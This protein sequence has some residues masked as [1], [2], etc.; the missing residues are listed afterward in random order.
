[1]ANSQPP[2]SRP[3]VA[4]L[5]GAFVFGDATAKGSDVLQDFHQNDTSHKRN[6]RV[7]EQDAD[8]EQDSTQNE[9]RRRVAVKPRQDEARAQ[10]AARNTT[11]QSHSL[12]E[13]L[14][15]HVQRSGHQF[16]DQRSERRAE[17]QQPKR[18]PEQPAILLLER[19]T[20]RLQRL[21]AGRGICGYRSGSL[22]NGSAVPAHIAVGGIGITDRLTA[23][24]ATCAHASY[25]FPMQC[26]VLPVRMNSCPCEMAME[27]RSELSPSSPIGVEWS[28]LKPAVA[29]EAT[30]TLPR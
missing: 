7:E 10:R 30:K 24:W 16:V 6:G 23:T 1:M 17:E 11:D 12:I 9:L 19:R 21:T 26:N 18:Q 4:R 28:S 15:P 22:E 14:K 13:E 20:S 5:A 3:L 29:V 27:E 2:L 8:A 25:F